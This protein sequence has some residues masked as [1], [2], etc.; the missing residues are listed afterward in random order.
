MAWSSNGRLI[1]LENM[2]LNIK[3]IFTILLCLTAV[4]F[5]VS[6]QTFTGG[7]GDGYFATI[8]EMVDM[9][10]VPTALSVSINQATVQADPTNL[11]PVIFDVVFSEDVTDFSFD[12]VTWIGTATGIIGSVSPL[13]TGTTFTV[14]V[15]S[16]STEGTLVPVIEANKVENVANK[17]NAAS[18]STDNSVLYEFPLTVTIEQAIGQADPTNGT[19]INFTATFSEAVTGFDDADVTINNSGGGTATATITGFGPYNIEI[20]G[21]SGSGDITVSIGANVCTDL[22]GNSNTASTSVDNK[23]DFDLN[24]PTI[25]LE[26]ATS[27]PDPTNSTTMNFTATFNE[28][29]TGF[30]GSDVTI[31]NTGSGT[32]IATV[33][34]TGPYNIEVSGYNGSGDITVSI[35][36]NVCTDLSGNSNTASTSVDNKVDFDLEAPTIT[37]EQAT[38]QP[39][40]TNSTTMNF[41]A[42]FSEEVTGFDGSDVTINN[43]GSGTAITTVTGTGPY[44]IE[45]SGYNGS[46][47]IT[48]SIGANVCTDLSG[49]SNTASTSVDNK[50]DFDLEAPTITLEQ[51]TSQPDPTNSTTMNFTATFSEEVTGFDGSDVTINNTGSGT[52]TATVTG[53]GPYNIEI[54]GYNGT[55]VI[56]VSIGNNVCADLIGNANIASTS[57]DNSVDYAM[58]P[59]NVIINQNTSQTDPVNNLPILF[60]VEFSRQVVDFSFDDITWTGSATGIN[61]SVTPTG[62]GTNFSISVTNAATEGTLIPVIEAGKVHDTFST[63]NVASTSTDNIVTYDNSRPGIEIYIEPGQNNPTNNNIV[64]FRAILSEIASGFDASH[65]NVSGTS[66]ANTASLKG[67]PIDYTIDVEGMANDGTVIIDI[68]E[69]QFTDN[70]N[71]Q[72]T[73]SVNIQNTIVYDVTR[74]DV[75]ISTTETSPTNQTEIPVSFEFSSEVTG[76]EEGDINL[77]NAAISGF[78]Q[79]GT[80]AWQATVIPEEEGVIEIQIPADVTTDLAL[81]GNNASNL[82]QIEYQRGE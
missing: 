2:Q 17:Q 30:D 72:N 23:V 42:T 80:S 53:T 69:N 63:P 49:N 43:T 14:T 51:A 59:L 79:S 36:A 34:G 55:G 74:P 39:D 8:E 21:Y 73:Q 76:I 13:A 66:G 54:S 64:S 22:S 35:G 15:T 61:G 82:L 40:P 1:L 75:I 11:L 3:I 16:V 31:N 57:T 60:D 19:P 25:T 37:L 45:V 32:V 44:N 52:A 62:T 20:S 12:D 28:E 27:Q 4:G 46:G 29:V 81:N 41:T 56:T 67:G 33:T 6:G 38:S 71:N 70:A 10:G 24:A 68:A 9:T 50:V 7:S 65:I 5:S 18:S 48:V 58:G 78:S 26:Q 47:D 77:N